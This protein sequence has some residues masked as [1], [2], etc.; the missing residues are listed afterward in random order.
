MSKQFTPCPA[1]GAIGEIG[2]KCSFCGTT[3]VSKEDSV[4]SDARIV[5]QRTISAQRYAEKIS[6]YH[7]VRYLGYG[8]TKVSIGEMYGLV[9]LNGDIIYPLG[10]DGIDQISK[11]TIA[12]GSTEAEGVKYFNLDTGMYADHLGFVEDKENPR[13]LYRIDV[14]NGWKPMNTYTNLEGEVHSYDYAELIVYPHID[15]FYRSRKIYL[16]HHGNECSLWI[17]YSRVVDNDYF[18]NTGIY[19]DIHWSNSKQRRKTWEKHVETNPA[20]PICV[21]E[22][23]Q[24]KYTF[25]VNNRVVQIVVRT[26]SG[27]DVPI[28]LAK[29]DPRDTT[30]YLTNDFKQIYNEW[31]RAIGKQI[32]KTESEECEENNVDSTECEENNVDSTYTLFIVLGIILVAI[33]I[34][35]A[36][37]IYLLIAY[38][39]FGKINYL[40]AGMV[41]IGCAIWITNKTI[42]ELLEFRK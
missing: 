35:F 5:R 11:D 8:L 32:L 14:H 19:D 28:T 34:C 21:L 15:K 12:I 1:C 22:G 7:D 6:I 25:E 39:D 20:Y 27:V 17:L 26:S 36:G 38:N 33:I 30:R 40:I 18:E 29:E 31:C 2:Q 24:D 4:I 42:K 9:N 37:G 16:L 41:S 23:I 10:S 13:K 3:I